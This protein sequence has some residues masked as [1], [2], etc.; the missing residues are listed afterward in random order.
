MVEMSFSRRHKMAEKITGR[1]ALSKDQQQ[2]MDAVRELLRHSK[3]PIDKVE[4]SDIDRF[5]RQAG[6]DATQIIKDN[7]RHQSDYQNASVQQHFSA[8]RRIV[9]VNGAIL[10]EVNEDDSLK[11]AKLKAF[12]VLGPLA[13][14]E[15]VFKYI[16][17]HRAKTTMLTVPKFIKNLKLMMSIVQ[18]APENFGANNGGGEVRDIIDASMGA[19]RDARAYLRAN[20]EKLP[21]GVYNYLRGGEM[22]TTDKREFAKYLGKDWERDAENAYRAARTLDLIEKA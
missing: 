7:D 21:E 15:E 13:P 6:M 22:Q 12:R 9:A 4:L 11:A 8:I 17:E 10:I 19:I 3:D 18:I 5:E 14:Q 16:E 1:E 2:R 20:K